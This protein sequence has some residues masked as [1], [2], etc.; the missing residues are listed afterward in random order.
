M[1]GEEFKPGHSVTAA[2]AV[3]L[4]ALVVVDIKPAVLGDCEQSLGMEKAGWKGGLV[5]WEAGPQGTILQGTGW[6]TPINR[7]QS[8]H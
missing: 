4:D 7:Q 1:E 8:K 3:E 5:S 6:L 2:D